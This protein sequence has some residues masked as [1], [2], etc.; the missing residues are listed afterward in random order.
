MYLTLSLVLEECKIFLS[1]LEKLLKIL[2]LH[3]HLVLAYWIF[4]VPQPGDS[5]GTFSVCDSKLPPV[6]TCLTSQ[7][8]KAFR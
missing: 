4:K 6:T 8:V 5:E 2:H 1:N 3:S 7:K